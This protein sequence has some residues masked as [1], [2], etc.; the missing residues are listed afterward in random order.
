M[1]ALV[2]GSAHRLGRAIALGLGKAGFRVAV[3][4]RSSRAGAEET[5]RLLGGAP[6]IE[7][8]QAREPARIV[9]EAAKAL[10]G[11]TLLVCNAA[12][13]EKAPSESLPRE[14]F[15]AMLSANL[16]GPFYL[17]QAALPHLR[18][19]G[20]GSMV[21]LL[22]VCGTSQVW[23]GYAHYAASKAGLAALTR[24]LA[25]EW[26]PEVRVNGVAPGSVV[27]AGEHLRHRIPLGRAGTPD[28]V[29]RAVLFLA[30]E[31]FITGQILTVDGGRSVNP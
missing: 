18:R 16:T 10:G 21:T 19:G 30:Q 13:I 28:D 23:K 17:M 5:A 24:L 7:G 2:T 9:A 27:E 25:V 1:Q 14:R 20:G 3:P 26:A 11:L 8:D 12:E 15:E 22:D 29:A 6:L 4:Y 31:P